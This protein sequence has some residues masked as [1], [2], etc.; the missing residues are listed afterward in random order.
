MIRIAIC[1]DEINICEKIKEKLLRH[2]IDRVDVNCF[3]SAPAI[4]DYIDK[5][6]HGEID[7]VI[8]D[9]KLKYDHGVDVATYLNKKYS[10]INFIF[11][12]GYPDGHKRIF[13]VEPVFY[14]EKPI[15]D[16]LLYEAVDRAIARMQNTNS[17]SI[18]FQSNGEIYSIRV[19]DIDYAESKGRVLKI[20]TINKVYA[21]Y[22][23]LSDLLAKLPSDF[24][25]CHKSFCVNMNKIIRLGKNE[26]ELYNSVCIPVSRVNS[27]EVKEK[28]TEFVIQKNSQGVFRS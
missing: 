9:I 22:M 8:L 24:L 14:L 21:T 17:M 18:A 25:K 20:H 4:C 1:D 10:S 6:V 19:D 27:M 23:K 28:Y 26:I 11:F 12:S 16:N 5:T 13:E 2:Y 7:I 3:D 15:A